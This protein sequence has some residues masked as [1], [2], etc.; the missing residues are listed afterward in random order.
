[1]LYVRELI[2]CMEKEPKRDFKMIE[3]VNRISGNQ[4][5]TIREKRA[6]RRSVLRALQALRDTGSVLVRPPRAARGGFAHYRWMPCRT[7]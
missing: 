4:T 3:L 5:L 7:L 6:I 2:D 1:M